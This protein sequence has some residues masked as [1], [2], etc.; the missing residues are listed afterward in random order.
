MNKYMPGQPAAKIG[1]VLPVYNQDAGYIRE[2]LDSILAQRFRNFKVVIVIDGANETTREA[3]RKASRRLTVPFEIFE[4]EENRGIAFSLNAGF[5]RLADCDY[6]TWVSSDNRYLPEFLATLT[7]ALDASPANTVLAYSLFHVINERGERLQEP[8]KA[9]MTFMQRPKEHILQ[10]CF[11]GASFLFKKEA[12]LR[13]GGYDPRFEKAEDHEFWMRLLQLGEI[14]FVPAALMEYRLGGKYAYT[15]NSSREEIIRKSALASI[16]TRKRI[17][18]LPR[19]TVLLPVYNQEKYVAQAMQSVLGQSFSSLQLVV[20]DDGSTDGTWQEINKVF[21]KR[22]ILLC[23]KK[24]RGKSAALNFASRFALGEYVL[25]M[26]GD[27]WLEPH[28][29]ETL[30]EEMERLPADVGL[31]YANRQLWLE[32]EGALQ[33]GPVI[34]GINYGDRHEVLE[35]QQT[36][37]PRL[38]RKAALESVGGWRTK[39]YDRRLMPED[40]D[41]M[42]RLADSYRF[43]WVNQTLYHQRRHPGNIT[44]LAGDECRRQVRHLTREAQR[45]WSR[46]I[47]T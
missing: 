27:D 9:M 15:T 36:H 16:E 39:I 33:A 24:N 8:S 3:V 20:T 12:Y 42:L 28:A 29:L 37:C 34:P 7:A 4:Q 44:V 6:L 47:V 11:I 30:V 41:L 40:F 43:S 26:D 23:L 38:Y 14:K 25:E 17:A 5:A 2:C 13:T 45:R 21:D 32:S 46:E 22:I 35:K 18:D 1:L 10:Q 19:V 31:V